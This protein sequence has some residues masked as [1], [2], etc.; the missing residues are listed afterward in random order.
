M[1]MSKS[2]LG[3]NGL[4]ALAAAVFAIQIGRAAMAPL[5]PAAVAP[6]RAAVPGRK[7]P[8]PAVTPAAEPRQPLASYAPV[9]AR[10]LFSP[11]RTEGAAP[12]GAQQAAGRPFLYGIVISDDLSIAYLED[13]ASKKVSG[14]R[15]GDPVAGGTLSRIAPD[16][17]VLKRPEGPVDVPLRDPAKPRPPVAEAGVPGVPGQPAAALPRPVAMPALP[18][19]VEAPVVPPLPPPASLLRRLPPVSGSLLFAPP[20]PNAP[21]R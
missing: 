1:S 17:V 6:R 20:I 13:P 3:L 10:N 18:S 7:P 16:H 21:G 19:S 9:A 11:S 12:G 15:I 5:G 4:L 14:Y 8:A 2:L